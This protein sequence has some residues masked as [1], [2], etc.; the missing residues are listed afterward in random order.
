[1]TGKRGERKDVRLLY[2]DDR[3]KRAVDA[4]GRRHGFNAQDLLMAH[5]E[6]FGRTDY[7]ILSAADQDQMLALQ[8]QAAGWTKP[9]PF[10]LTA[11]GYLM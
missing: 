3:T 2:R 4:W 7:D 5:L 10:S 9:R 8:V 1:M 6:K 11:E